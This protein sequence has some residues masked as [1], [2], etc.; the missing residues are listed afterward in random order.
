MLISISYFVFVIG[1]AVDL[2]HDTA[3]Q[4]VAVD[5]SKTVCSSLLWTPDSLVVHAR[6]TGLGP[7][8]GTAALRYRRLGM[9]R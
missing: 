7:G 9:G 2:L 4:A 8:R 3:R 6:Q 5:E 1:I